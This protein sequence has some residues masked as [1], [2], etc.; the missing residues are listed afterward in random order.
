VN[1]IPK[2][3]IPRPT[4]PASIFSRVPSFL[5]KNSGL[6][7][8]FTISNSPVFE[9]RTAIKKVINLSDGDDLY[10]SLLSLSDISVSGISNSR[11]ELRAASRVLTRSAAPIPFPATSA[12]IKA[13]L[14]LPKSTQS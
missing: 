13:Y 1:G 9:S 3:N 8:A 10:I 14:P 5:N 6:C 11:Y 2:S 7:P 12:M 4:P